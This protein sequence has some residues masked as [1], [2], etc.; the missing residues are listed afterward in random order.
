M[1]MNKHE[2]LA[3]YYGLIMHLAKSH[4]YK[5]SPQLK[6]VMG[7]DDLFMEGVIGAIIAID[8]YK[9]DKGP[10]TAWVKLKAYYR[11]IDSIREASPF[12]QKIWKQIEK[13]MKTEKELMQK[14]AR[15]PSDTELADRMDVSLER[16]REIRSWIEIDHVDIGS[17]TII[18]DEQRPDEINEIKQLLRCIDTCIRSNLTEQEGFVW[19]ERKI[20]KRTLKEIGEKIKLKIGAVRKIEAIAKTKL[21]LCLKDGRWHEKDLPDIII[22]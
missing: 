6:Q 4:Y 10:L 5:A 16:I 21:K 17:V 12:P 20:Y 11:I 22:D 14:L 1:G 2:M 3:Q 7:L 13:L 15:E 9:H 8:T 19:V 18:D